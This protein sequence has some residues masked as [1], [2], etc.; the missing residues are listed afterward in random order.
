MQ[1]TATIPARIDSPAK[2]LWLLP[3]LR[4]MVRNPIEAWPRAVYREHLH[5]SRMPGRDVV[6]VMCPEL[7]RQVLVNE[8]DSFEKG[9]MARRALGPVL[10]DAIL[11]AEGTRWRAQRQ[12]AAPLFRREQLLAFLP[13]MIAA[14]ERSR[15]RLLSYPTASE[16][17]VAREMMRTT[18]DIVLATMLSGSGADDPAPIERAIADYLE[19]TSWVM[20]LTILGAPRWVPY[21]GMRKAARGRDF[22]KQFVAGLTS[23]NEPGLRNNLLSLLI[24]ANDPQTGGSMSE[25][26]VRAN[27]LTFV[28]AGHETTALALTWTFY[29][30]SLHPEIEERVRSEIAAVTGGTPVRGEHID[31]LRYAQQVIQEAMRLYPPAPLIVRQ[32]RRVLRLGTETI[33]PG[34]FVYV[35]VYAVHRHEEF[36]DQPDVFDP[37]R[38]APEAVKARDRYV[39]LPFGAGPR[40]C[41]GMSF[42]L[43]EAT[44]VLAVLV[45]SMRLRLRP[46]YI[47]QPKLRITLRPAG[48][49]PMRLG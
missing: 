45:S 39:Y 30:L 19:S 32:A 49:M 11:I 20:A 48:G 16:I 12:A 41:I 37:D 38:F 33:G 15:D 29:L 44:V 40:I 46:G 23:G 13:V 22:L 24:G 31:S 6:F 21:P 26:D 1:P 7:I 9:A 34:T 47:P 2:P 28:M 42:A 27:I 18:L 3:L 5:R 10:G 36:W 35:P 25:T 14:A 17:D 8:A 43:M 4:A